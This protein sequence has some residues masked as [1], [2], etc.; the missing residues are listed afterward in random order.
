MCGLI[1]VML[2]AYWDN[3]QVWSLFLCLQRVSGLG[4]DTCGESLMA[5]KADNPT[6]ISGPGPPMS[7]GPCQHSVSSQ[8]RLCPC[9]DPSVPAVVSAAS[10]VTG[11]VG[12]KT[13]HWNSVPGPCPGCYTHI[14]PP[15]SFSRTRG[16]DNS[17][18]RRSFRSRAVFPADLYG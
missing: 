2:G 16:V 17:S 14:W 4:M 9:E 5:S 10:G 11:I 7:K 18:E 8:A 13:C 1:G 15:N 12:T 6:F 3:G